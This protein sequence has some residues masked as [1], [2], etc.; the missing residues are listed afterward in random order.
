MHKSVGA[1]KSAL[2]QVCVRAL[3]CGKGVHKHAGRT[4]SSG[5]GFSPEI[6][7]ARMK[8]WACAHMCAHMWVQVHHCMYVCAGAATCL[9]LQVQVHRCGVHRCP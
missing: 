8:V 1:H 7:I 9:R 3:V 5:S 6:E 4:V 2:V